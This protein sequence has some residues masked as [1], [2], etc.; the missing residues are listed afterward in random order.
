MRVLFLGDGIALTTGFATVI[1]QLVAEG[2]RRGWEMAQIAGLDVPP[3]VDS[4]PYW[5]ACVRPFFPAHR[6][7]VMGLLVLA[8]V[9]EEIRPDAAVIVADPGAAGSWL[10]RLAVAD[11]SVPTVLYAPVEGAPV[12][13]AYADAFRRA[14]VAF[15][16][17][18]WSSEVLRD[19]HGLEAPWRYHG[20]DRGVFKPLDEGARRR[21]RRE[22]GWEGKFVIAYVARN[23]ARKA[24][25]RLIKALALL[26]EHQLRE[27]Q[28]DVHL[29]LH[30]QPYDTHALGGWDLR[31]LAH[32]CGV[33]DAVEFAP[34]RGATRGIA[35]PGLA[36]RL[37]AADLYVSPSKVEGFGLPLVE[38]MAC[39]LPVMVT[40]DGGNQVEVVGDAAAMRLPVSDRD[41]WFNGAQL[42][43]VAPEA[44]ASCVMDWRGRATA[45]RERARERGLARADVFSWAP[46]V[47]ALAEA[48]ERV[49]AREG[50]AA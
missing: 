9:V 39:G 42:C 1:R 45:Q 28:R 26:H 48:V 23:A 29:Y 46:A 47:D 6:Q 3:S 31:G 4:R 2:R 41:T 12:C 40:D 30:C 20:V 43:H 11:P 19:E 7:D 22:L 44:I 37:A 10:D 18:R 14:T 24:H 16:I 15:T 38:A 17:T 35:A 33:S 25:D 8:E 49:A 27:Y 36:Q 34:E 32:W 5:D 13:P 50:R 21:L